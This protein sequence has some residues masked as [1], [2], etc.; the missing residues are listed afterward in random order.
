M[1]ADT[2]SP[3]PAAARPHRLSRRTWSATAR[4]ARIVHVGLGAF[5]R[6]HLAWYTASAEPAGGWG[7]SGFTGR[8]P[9][10]AASLK[11]QQGLYALVERGPL[12][13]SVSVVDSIVE[14]HGGGE[15]AAL[16]AALAAPETALVTLTVT[17]AAYRPPAPAERAGG[18]GE[19]R[20]LPTV[21]ERL[22]A[23]LAARV[24]AGAGPLALVSCD[25]LASNGT[26]LRK[27]VLGEL[28]LL[29]PPAADWAQRN[30]SFVRTSVDRITPRTS[31]SDR[32]LV[33]RELGLHDAAPV[34]CEPFS[35]WVLCGE[36]PAGRPAWEDAGARFVNDIG[37]WEARKLWLLNGGHC[38]LA[39]LGLARGHASVAQALAEREIAGALE[40]Y[41]DLAGVLLPGGA[42]LE[43][44]SYRA[45]LWA[46][47]AN[48]RIGYPLTQIAADGL[49]KLR[50]RVLPVIV[51]AR[52]AGVD[53]GPALAIV[54]AWADWLIAEPGR[55]GTD[56]NHQLLDAALKGGGAQARRGLLEL[57]EIV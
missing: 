24:R 57:L 43:L 40:R 51:A 53:A 48:A 4:T 54:Q 42:Q 41:W 38:L 28:A 47:F 9:Q 56:Q 31:Q 17:E 10:L 19:A 49:E 18:C 6:A 1:S 14:A 8:S 23:G 39:Y 52:R 26:V 36:F 2:L 5:S 12:T 13:D 29:D 44:N 34:V 32:E 15:L 35:D 11:P 55:A 21:G 20:E 16:T 7:I 27:L 46:R 25:N 50:N 22:A 33:E 37:P 30:V 45:A 3:A